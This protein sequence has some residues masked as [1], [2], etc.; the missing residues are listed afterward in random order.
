MRGDLCRIFVRTSILPRIY[1]RVL[2]EPRPSSSFVAFQT[3]NNGGPGRS[4]ATCTRMATVHPVA[5]TGFGT[6]TNE[7]YDRYE[8]CA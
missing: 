3:G 1:C 2:C 5:Q 4:F 8:T 6:G 7:L